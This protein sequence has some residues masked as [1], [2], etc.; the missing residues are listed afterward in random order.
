MNLISVKYQKLIFKLRSDFRSYFDIHYQQNK[1]GLAII[2]EAKAL[3]NT[4][5][6]Y[7]FIYLYL[8]YYVEVWGNHYT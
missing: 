2:S 5:R 6:S 8:S 4:Y 3:I 7:T 1:I